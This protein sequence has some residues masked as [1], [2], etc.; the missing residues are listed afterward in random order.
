VPDGEHIRRYSD[1]IAACKTDDEFQAWFNKADGAYH[2]GVNGFWDF[3]I[4][5][6][7]PMVRF[8]LGNPHEKTAL[9]IGCGGGR[10]LTAASHYFRHVIGLD[11]HGS[12]ARIKRTPN[13]GLIRGDGETIPLQNASVDFIYSFI[14]MQHL[15]SGAAFVSYLREARRCLIPGGLAML[16]YGK[17]DELYERK[18]PANQTSLAM[19]RADAVQGAISARFEV[20]EEGDSWRFGDKTLHRGAQGFMLLR[21]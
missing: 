8:H 15:Q 20:L 6:A 2:A 12:L 17:R 9:E 14:V 5:I 18:V 4:H 13:M 21:R 7:T 16:Y 1:A 19:P 3:A 10:L 11:I